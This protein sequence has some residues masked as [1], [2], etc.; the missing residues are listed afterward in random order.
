ML[1][2][3]ELVSTHVKTAP[4]FSTLLSQMVI[5]LGSS[6]I[7]ETWVSCRRARLY[8]VD[9]TRVTWHLWRE[10]VVFQ[11]VVIARSSASGC[12]QKATSSFCSFLTYLV[13]A[14]FQTRVSLS[15]VVLVVK[16]LNTTPRHLIVVAAVA[17]FCAWAKEIYLFIFWTSKVLNTLMIDVNS[18]TI[19]IGSPKKSITH[20]KMSHT[21]L[22]AQLLNA[23]CKGKTSQRFTG[24]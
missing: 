9:R 13:S 23:E 14:V 1:S 10:N 21:G 2:G 12:R 22:S 16:H 11:S 6:W 17:E 15:I 18:M 20:Y 7:M 4:L 8:A 24:T 3:L 19:S 5:S